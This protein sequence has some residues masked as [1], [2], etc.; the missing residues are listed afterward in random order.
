MTKSTLILLLALLGSLSVCGSVSAKQAYRKGL[1][2]MVYTD[3]SDIGKQIAAYNNEKKEGKANQENL[4]K[5]IKAIKTSIE[6]GSKVK[7]T[8]DPE[9]KVGTIVFIHFP[10]DKQ[11]DVEK[12]LQTQV[13]QKVL[14][15]FERDAV[16]SLT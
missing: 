8:K 6:D 16:V 4:N 5:I 3:T 14:K 15:Y 1:L 9:I 2:M 13:D 7:M 12:Y 10:E 11:E